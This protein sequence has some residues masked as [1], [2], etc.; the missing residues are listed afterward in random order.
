ML[1]FLLILHAI[2]ALLLIVFVLLQ[3]SEG[4][5]L[6]FGGGGNNL[7]SVRGSANFLTRTTAIFA[8]LFMATSLV[9]AVLF[10]RSS[11]NNGS[12]LNEIENQPSETAP[13]AKN[14]TAPTVPSSPL[15]PFG[16]TPAVPKAQ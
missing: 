9:L 8:T 11:K 15:T 7:F 14:K 10:A 6:G 12:I 1:T 16:N 2:I 5:S 4:G 13:A 3:K